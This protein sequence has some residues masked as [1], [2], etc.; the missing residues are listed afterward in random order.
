VPVHPLRRLF[1]VLTLGWA[2]LIYYLSDQPRLDITSLFPQQDK[3]LHLIAYSVLGFLAMGSCKTNGCRHQA[4]H[5]WLVVTLVGVYGV[6]DEVHQYFVPGR[7]SDVFDVLADAAGGLL[8]AGLMLLLL[9]RYLRPT[10][11]DVQP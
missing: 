9:R 8:G 11:P 5:Y 10:A 2:G 6:L 4:F 3:A 1:M 7:Q